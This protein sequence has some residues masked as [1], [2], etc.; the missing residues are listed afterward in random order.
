VSDQE[1]GREVIAAYLWLEHCIVERLKL[2]VILAIFGYYEATS[3]EV[4][5]I[6]LGYAESGI[7]SAQTGMAATADGRHLVFAFKDHIIKVYDVFAGKMIRRFK[8]PALD[9]FDLQVTKDGK[10]IL[11]GKKEVEIWN[12]KESKRIVTLPLTF[13][14]TK[15]AFS[16]GRNLLA[17]GQFEGNTAVFDL[18][19]GKLLRE[20]VYKKHHVSALAI[21][22]R[23][24]V[25]VV[26]VMA[27]MNALL[28]LKLFDIA[29]GAEVA[30]SS[31]KDFFTMA[32]FDGAGERIVAWGREGNQLFDAK[33]LRHLGRIGNDGV[34]Y[35][36]RN[37][38]YGSLLTDDKVM[39]L[40]DTRAFNVSNV[41]TGER[42]F[43]T[44]REDGPRGLGRIG[45]GTT[46]IY[47]LNP[48]MD[49]VIVNTTG[50]NI[51]QLYDLKRNAMIGY[52]FCDSN[53]DFAIVARDGRIDGTPA[54]HSKLY[55][56]SRKS[57]KKTSLESTFEK[58][59]TPK[60]LSQFI[61]SEDVQNTAFDSD[62]ILDRIPVIALKA[63][64]ANKASDTATFETSQKSITIEVT[65]KQNPTEVTSVTLHQNAK[66]VRTLQNEGRSTYTFPAS[67]NHSFGDENYFF[68]T[69]S[70]KAG[71]DSEK[72]KFKVRYKG[73]VDA[74]PKLFLVTIGI[75]QYK[76][77]KYNLNYAQADADGVQLMI[78]Q[79]ANSLFQEIISFSIR[80][81][82]A[83]KTNILA[84]LE[85]IK[86]K[87]EEQDM[88]VLYYAGHG[89][90]S[91]GVSRDKEFFIVPHDVTQL[92][93]KDELLF[94]K[95][96]SATE[97]KT[98]ARQ[99]NAQKQVFFLDAC[100]S[101][102]ALEGMENRT[103]GVAEEKAIA[104][105]AR[106][107]GSFWI[108]ST[109]TDQFASEFAKLGHG[110]FTHAL[111]EGLKGAADTN[112]DLRLT[113]RELST[114]I[115][116]KVPELSDQLKGSPQYPSAYSFGNDFPLAVYR[117]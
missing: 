3:Q 93:G 109:G 68:V 104:Q 110:I 111:I 31:K 25:I 51:N 98:A 40:T 99:I 11:I 13:E 114:Y 30:S 53:D 4:D 72:M 14:A 39:M 61:G 6:R 79:Q 22:P 34:Q 108:T 47:A 32:A 96:V 102:G 50:N 52:F 100:Q 71:I 64:T 87:S 77:P 37:M 67:L 26:G 23:S 54:A 89:V 1:L 62:N 83:V 76:N 113:V 66:P 91:E 41:R 5:V 8:G 20:I 88:L 97:L 18:N 21:H 56:T 103:R 29:T 49:K 35:A 12:W 10:I 24:N 106:S 75:N 82:Q 117:N 116:N 33:D 80:N 46:S 42:L 60:L 28:P 43:T 86:M 2:C 48:S 78:S 70:S 15:T 16:P 112:G 90:M 38:A 105:L 94:E 74:K 63:I 85:D 59:Y 27:A 107:T 7:V 73:T 58:G 45:V 57:D 9:L 44:M 69:A 65:V 115:E 36:G 55:W 19:E 95:A 81:D 101:S 17:V 84:A 92:Y